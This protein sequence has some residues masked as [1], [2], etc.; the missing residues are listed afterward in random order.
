MTTHSL[1]IMGNDSGSPLSDGA[2][3]DAVAT[4]GGLVVKSCKN[5]HETSRVAAIVIGGKATFSEAAELKP[6]ELHIL[7]F[8]EEGD[9]DGVIGA[10]DWINKWAAELAGKTIYLTKPTTP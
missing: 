4:Y 2:I 9:V 1:I 6:R 3:S 5:C 7:T 10:K 8:A